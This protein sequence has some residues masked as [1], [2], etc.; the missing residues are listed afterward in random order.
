MSDEMHGH[1][2][3]ASE[4]SELDLTTDA[5]EETQHL[6]R[7]FG[8]REILLFTIC[9]LVGVDSIGAIA[10][11]GP[12]AFSWLIILAVVFFFPQGLLFAELGTA[13]PEEGGP[14]IWARL[15]FGRLVGAVN[16]FLYWITNPVWFGGTLATLAIATYVTFFNSNN[17][18]PTWAFFTFGI[19]FIWIGTLSAILSFSVGKWIPISGAWARFLL[20]GF[21]TVSVIIFAAKHGIHGVTGG[22]F[23]VSYT[24]FV[25]LVG[26]IMFSLVG[27]ELPNTAGDE[28]KDAK[29][30][31]PYSI[32]RSAIASIILY[33]VPV[34]GILIVLPADQVTNIGG[35]I[36][37]IKSVFTVYGG[38]IASDGT[39]TLSGAGLLLGDFAAI[40]FIL[41]TLSS[42]TTWIMGSDRALAVSGYDGAAPRYL[43]RF[44]PRFGTPVRVNVL[45]GLLS[46]FVLYMVWLMEGGSDN[47]AKYF[48]AILGI[49]VSTTLVS[50]I[51]V[52]PAL[53]RLRVKLPNHPRPFRAPA[54]TFISIWLTIL[55]VFASIQ[56]I[57]PGFPTGW[58]SDN[59]R[60]DGWLASEK[61]KYL[62]TEGVPLLI[63]VAFGI[64]FYLL[65]APTR[66]DTGARAVAAAEA[67]EGEA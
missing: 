26:L 20:L 11:A 10:N 2:P 24:G 64:L 42:G 36:D 56:L 60:P 67:V 18:L 45:S 32:A 3:T 43:G 4:V 7:H 14:Y 53:W 29:K 65:G 62:M 66:R 9:T 6:Q 1:V 17:A 27:F 30:D 52:F 37:A 41:C 25:A 55:V 8:R 38:S 54:A 49:A 13:F 33:G 61:W 16:N 19:V 34:L 47:A 44:S 57:A 63:F 28:M 50:Y 21:F 58:F 59:Y 23:K 12:E 39:A 22:D 31:V 48:G 46:T 35:F 15:A 40:L 5:V 51:G